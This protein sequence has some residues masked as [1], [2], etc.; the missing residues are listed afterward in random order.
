MLDSD[1]IQNLQQN[2]EMERLKLP[3]ELEMEKLARL[4]AEEEFKK[5][6]EVC[7]RGKKV[8]E[9]YEALLK[10]VKTDLADRDSVVVLR[11]RNIE[12]RELFEEGKI[13]IGE[14]TKKNNELE[15][16]V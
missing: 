4:H 2:V 16:E 14:L 8:Q 15:S 1:Q 11:K 9:R 13:S 12:L 7:Q 10:K 5:R 6:E 3:D